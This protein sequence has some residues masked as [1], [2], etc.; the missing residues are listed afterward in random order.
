MMGATHAR[1]SESAL[2]VGDGGEAVSLAGS[3]L[4]GVDLASGTRVS[5]G[6]FVAATG[7]NTGRKVRAEVKGP[8]ESALVLSDLIL[9]ATA[10]PCPDDD[11]SLSGAPLVVGGDRTV[12]VATDVNLEDVAEASATA[13]FNGEMAGVLFTLAAFL[14]AGARATGTDDLAQAKDAGRT[15]RAG[16][17][18]ACCSCS[19]MARS[20]WQVYTPLLHDLARRRNIWNPEPPAAK[21]KQ[22]NDDGRS[23]ADLSNGRGVPAMRA[24]RC[25][26]T[27]RPVDMVSSF[28]TNSRHLQ[29]LPQWRFTRKCY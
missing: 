22:G 1:R 27:T 12:L 6:S 15:C 16:C 9:P 25:H 29:L 2:F 11:A 3:I 28:P 14:G 24:S 8:G 10:V 7:L 23:F 13:S 4:R 19:L 17:F 21:G 26:P 5:P 18:A 20:S